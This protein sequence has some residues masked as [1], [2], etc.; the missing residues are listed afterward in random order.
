[1]TPAELA[2]LHAAAFAPERGWTETEF[3]TLL[4]QPHTALFIEENGFALVR[5]LAGESELLTLAVAPA[6]QGRGIGHALLTRW[7]ANADADT[8]FLDVAA[9]NAAAMALYRRSGFDVTGT[10]RAYYSRPDGSAV[11]AVLMAR[12]LT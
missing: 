1:M 10:R 4:D 8:A 2:R 5:T 12:A 11:D 6:H 3:A 9:D 7:L